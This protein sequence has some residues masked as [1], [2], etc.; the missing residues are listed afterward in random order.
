M[1]TTLFDPHAVN[2]AAAFFNGVTRLQFKTMD[3]FD[4]VAVNDL[5]AAVTFS[6]PPQPG[7]ASN[8]DLAD[9]CQ[10]WDPASN[11]YS[12]RGCAAMP[13][14]PPGMELEVDKKLAA[15]GLSINASWVMV[16]SRAPELLANCT[17]TI[18]DCP[19]DAGKK[20]YLDPWR[21]LSVPAVQCAPGK[22]IKMLVYNG[23]DC[24]IWNPAKAPCYWNA[25]AQGFYGQVRSSALLWGM[26]AL[27]QS[28]CS[29]ALT[30]LSRPTSRSAGPATR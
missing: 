4:E 27:R 7:A 29:P 3:A 11:S 21:P 14:T 13:Q 19:R 12:T 23:T 20:V 2:V 18:L 25:T 16:G 30:S 22:Q 15:S 26:R 24:R 10:F 1:V 28:F 8:P 9:T 5:P 17:R 6:L